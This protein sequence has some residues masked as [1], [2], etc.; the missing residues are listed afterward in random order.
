MEG[1]W[2]DGR[3]METVASLKGVDLAMML[4]GPWYGAPLDGSPTVLLDTGTHDIHALD[5]DAP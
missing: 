2:I 4:L 5:L 1:S 3:R